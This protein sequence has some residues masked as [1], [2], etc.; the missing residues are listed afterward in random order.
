MATV[1]NA[2]IRYQTLDKC[3]RNT[4]RRY[5]MS[6][7]LE[8]VNAALLEHDPNS[9]GIQRRQLFDDINFM[10]SESG[11][12]ISLDRIKDGKKV[13]YTYA[14]PNF[15]IFNHPLNETE[16][17]QISSAISLL[18]SFTGLP[19]FEW[20]QDV[21]PVIEGKLGLIGR[22]TESVAFESNEVISGAEFLSPLF[23]AIFNRKVQK[24]TYKDFKSDEPY[25]LTFHPHYIKQYNNRWFAF[26]L[27]SE[28]GIPT[29]NLAFDR[30]VLL[31]DCNDTYIESDIDWTDYFDDIIGVTKPIG[32]EVHEVKL[33]FNAETA[34]YVLTKPIHPSQKNKEE[35]SGLQVRVYVIPNYELESLIL[36]YG[37]RVKVLEPK[38]LRDKIKLRLDTGAEGYK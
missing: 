37:E 27:N 23:A 22:K 1:K 38:S 15:S 35:E 33:Q 19:Q 2:L 17:K 34:P 24:V 10:E 18:T 6:D 28:K 32:I 16:I 13:F 4:G 31:E 21:M 5:Y 3:F 26:G 25:Q 8:A 7:L 12:L 30:I 29:W 14:D 11:W 20:I 9:S 36:S